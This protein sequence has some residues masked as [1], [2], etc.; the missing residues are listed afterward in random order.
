MTDQMD[1]DT[2]PDADST[3]VTTR[4]Q[5]EVYLMPKRYRE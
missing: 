2:V 4:I 5:G 1:T 3:L